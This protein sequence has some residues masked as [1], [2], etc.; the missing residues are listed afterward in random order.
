[1]LGDVSVK[2]LVKIVLSKVARTI[3]HSGQGSM[4]VG[5]GLSSVAISQLSKRKYSSKIEF[6]HRI[7]G[8]RET[9]FIRDR[10]GLVACRAVAELPRG[11]NI[12]IR[13]PSANFCHECRR[14]CEKTSIRGKVVC[15][16]F[17]TAVTPLGT[18]LL[19]SSI[20]PSAQRT[21]VSRK[22]AR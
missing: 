20:A 11:I 9:H 21:L 6:A 8:T 15:P 12:H 19:K 7:A 10:S 4:I 17:E 2:T 16:C 5:R 14:F 1:M 18:W 22:M 3:C 13:R